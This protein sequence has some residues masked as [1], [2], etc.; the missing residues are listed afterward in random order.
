MK[1][2]LVFAALVC[3]C[4][5]AASI[6]INDL[7][8]GTHIE[9]DEFVLWAIDHGKNYNAAEV[10]QR[11]LNFMASKQRIANLNQDAAAKGM[12]T[13]FALNRFSDMT[14]EEFKATMMGYVPRS[15][16]AVNALPATIPTVTEIPTSFDWRNKG[17]VTPVKDQGQCG[18][19]WAFST[20]E[21]VESAWFMAK[22][23][24]L[25]LA[26][27]Q[28][29]DCDTTDLGCN[30]GD[31]PTAFAYVKQN[32][33]EYE[34]DYPYF[35]GNSGDSGNCQ[36]KSSK[37][38]AHIKGFAYATQKH[39]E[40]QM[41]A[42]SLEKGPLSICVDAETWQD[43]SSGI[44]KSDCDNDLDHCVQLTGWGEENGVKFWSIRNSWNTSW[45]ENGYI[46]VERNKDLCGVS[47]EATYAIID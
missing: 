8:H 29:V 1:T 13:K 46:R 37:V 20:T 43:Y 38:V 14:P 4:S 15:Q 12:N 19:C 16:S 21:G 39:N 7:K 11:Y 47:D 36:Y 2:V 26:P 24:L 6:K 5:V 30:G 9:K 45:G 28:I 34:K 32:G 40:T 22:K 42:V 17:A 25:V 18:S 3:F 44:I 23:Q 31:L 35:S 41:Q 10:N 27:Q 33:L